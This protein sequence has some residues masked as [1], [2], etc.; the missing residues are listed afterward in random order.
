MDYKYSNPY[1]L[2]LIIEAIKD[3]DTDRNFYKEL[4]GKVPLTEDSRIL[5]DLSMDEAKHYE[6]FNDIYYKL[7][8]EKL[9]PPLKG[10]KKEI[11]PNLLENYS[12][13]ILSELKGVE[14]YRKLLFAFLNQEIRD[15]MTEVISDEQNHAIKLN[16]LLTKGYNKK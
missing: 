11:S 8:G 2:E 1:I 10:E 16:Y 13:S 5:N 12:E 15:L 9:D 7:T 3:E 4:S 6:M 14:E